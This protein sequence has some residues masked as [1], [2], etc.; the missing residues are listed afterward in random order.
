MLVSLQH[1]A[2]EEL[3]AY[4]R[5]WGISAPGLWVHIVEICGLGADENRVST[6]GFGRPVGTRNM[7]GATLSGRTRVSFEGQSQE[8]G[9][10]SALCDDEPASHHLGRRASA[11]LFEPQCLLSRR[12]QRRPAPAAF[13]A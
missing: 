13:P 1:F 9:P 5:F 8:W 2:M 3:G 11:R 6:L 12:D 10:G 7:I 4:R